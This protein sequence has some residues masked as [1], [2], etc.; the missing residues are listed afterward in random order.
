MEPFPV[1]GFRRT[2]HEHFYKQMMI[3]V[4][5]TEIFFQKKACAPRYFDLQS[6]Q[7]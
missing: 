3:L 7:T 1:K 6:K 2:N 5:A 4:F